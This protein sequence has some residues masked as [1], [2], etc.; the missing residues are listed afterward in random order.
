VDL[1][2]TDAT[3]LPRGPRRDDLRAAF[4]TASLRCALSAG[5]V[6]AGEVRE[7]I[8]S[9]IAYLDCE[10]PEDGIELDREALKRMQQGR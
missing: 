6:E 2:E 4:N 7:V 8:E 3:S 10:R 1:S 5:K 9:L